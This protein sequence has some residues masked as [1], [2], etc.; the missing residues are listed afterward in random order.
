VRAAAA[1]DVG[2]HP[3]LIPQG[4]MQGL[5]DFPALQSHT[6]GEKKKRLH[7]TNPAG[8]PHS[9]PLPGVGYLHCSSHL[10]F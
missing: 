7:K 3:T 5:E 8:F 10:L 6:S 2:V 4:K 9:K 1:G